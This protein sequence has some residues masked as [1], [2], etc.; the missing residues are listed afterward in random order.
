MPEPPS[1]DLMDPRTWNL[2][3]GV[4]LEDGEPPLFS[5][6][7]GP[8]PPSTFVITGLFRIGQRL[9]VDVV[10]LPTPPRSPQAEAA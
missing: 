6:R 4:I 1:S 9:I 7:G 5:F 10:W 3:Q 2:A 8:G